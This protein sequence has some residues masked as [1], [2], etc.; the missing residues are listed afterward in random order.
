MRG[1][2]PAGLEARAR[3]GRLAGIEV[4]VTWVRG[5]RLASNCNRVGEQHVSS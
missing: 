2:K 5:G 4:R 1:D 3:R